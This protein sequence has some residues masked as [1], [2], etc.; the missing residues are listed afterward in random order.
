M[1]GCARLR[2]KHPPGPPVNSLPQCPEHAPRIIVDPEQLAKDIRSSAKGTAAGISGWTAELLIPLVDDD[3]CLAGLTSLIQAIAN[4]ELDDHSR[5]LLTTSLLLGI[6]KP[7]DIRP[8]AIGETFLKL[9]AKYALRLDSATI[10]GH[11]EPLQ[12]SHSLGGV[13]RAHQVIQAAIESHPDDHIAIHIDSTNAYNSANRAALLDSIYS[14]RNLSNTWRLFAFAYGH[15]STL[16]VRDRGSVIA[17]ISSQQ[18]AKQGCVLAGLGYAHLFQPVLEASIRGLPVTLRAIMDDVSI[19]GPPHAAFTAF[20][21][22]THFAQARD[23]SVNPLKTVVQQA[24]GQPTPLTLA[25]AARHGLKIVCGN[26]KYLGGMVGVDDAAATEWLTSK[27]SVLT[28]VIRAVRDPHF[29]AALAFQACRLNHNPRAIFYAR[30]MPLRVTLAPLQKFR[31][32]LLS[33][34]STRLHLP[35]P[36]PRSAYLSLSQPLG[37]AGMGIRDMALIAPAAKWASAAIAAP[38]LI[39]FTGTHDAPPPFVTDRIAAYNALISAGALR[40]A[41]SVTN[42]MEALDNPENAN[43]KTSDLLKILPADPALIASYYLVN[44][45][46][47]RPTAPLIQRALSRQLE[48]Q[49][50]SSFL[51]GP[52][53]TPLDSLRFHSCRD[54][55]SSRWMLPSPLHRYQT[56]LEFQICTALRL[57]LPPVH[58]L[59]TE[60][61]LC[62]SSMT[63]DP[64]HAF[65]CPTMKRKAITTR[66]DNAVRMITQHARN[67]GILSR[68]EP[69]D[70]KSLVPDAELFLTR[71]TIDIDLT[72]AFPLAPSYTDL[73]PGQLLPTKA[74]R[75]EKKYT[76]QSTAA[77]KRFVPIVVDVF[78]SLG[79]EATELLDIIEKE[80]AFPSVSDAGKRHPRSLFLSTFSHKWHTDNVNIITQWC[81]LMRMHMSKT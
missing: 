11:F 18:G 36:L 62:K 35:S 19:V 50:F 44:T 2:A 33:A 74:R 23:V 25:L 42:F 30:A 40:A 38:D 76:E 60:C 13:E 51:R 65:S 56:D 58:P 63:L 8:I 41:P 32:D 3:V 57:G 31:N 77:G 27:L 9:A 7:N 37:N 34:I 72:A 61:P 29:P 43:S 47:E 24:R 53:C 20:A 16:L 79:R 17:T 67:F 71:E 12:M 52:D 1:D 81:R 66:H 45:S 4:G 64:W 70:F 75:K 10:P 39:A 68:L 14:D 22:F 46:P 49:R 55:M 28:P 6:P 21:R 73:K 78:G 5:D 59:P 54:P 69:K 80:A 26:H 15:H 48:D